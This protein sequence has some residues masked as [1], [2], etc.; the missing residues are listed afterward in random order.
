MAQTKEGRKVSWIVVLKVVADTDMT[1]DPLIDQYT[2]EPQGPN[3][4]KREALAFSSGLLTGWPGPL[5]PVRCYGVTEESDDQVWMWLEARD[6]AR[7][8]AP[9]TIEQL[10]SAA[11]DFGAF[12]AQ[13]QSKLPDLVRYS[14]RWRSGGCAAGW[15]WFGPLQLI[16]FLS[17]MTV[18]MAPRRAVP[19]QESATPDCPVDLGRG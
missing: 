12:G 4:W 17:T 18:E 11:Y 19:E 10:A 9:W 16:I 14:W 3:Y 6:G 7:P 13:C 2:H 8:H 5:V 15:R 1:G